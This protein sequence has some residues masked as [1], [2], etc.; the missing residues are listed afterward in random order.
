[1]T[2]SEINFFEQ[3]VRNDER[4]KTLKQLEDEQE[5]QIQ[6]FMAKRTK[7]RAMPRAAQSYNV[8]DNW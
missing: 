4:K 7:K 3:K 5:K 8:W 6:D 1:M 2:E